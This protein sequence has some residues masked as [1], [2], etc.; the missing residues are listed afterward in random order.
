[1]PRILRAVL[2]PEI[3]NLSDG[4]AWRVVLGHNLDRA[5]HSIALLE[6]PE[7]SNASLRI[8]FDAYDPA[9]S[10]TVGGYRPVEQITGDHRYGSLNIDRAKR[11]H[12]WTF[13]ERA[14]EVASRYDPTPLHVIEDLDDT[15]ARPDRYSPGKSYLETEHWDLVPVSPETLCQNRQNQR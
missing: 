1:M 9:A 14:E 2:M 12:C 6:Q 3:A 10:A 15:I 7:G 8:L 4:S 13:A 11:R 5:Y